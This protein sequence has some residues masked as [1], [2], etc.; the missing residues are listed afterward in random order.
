LK[1]RSNNVMRPLRVL[2]LLTQSLDYP[3]GLGRYWPIARHMARL[4]YE[5]EIAAL[6]PRWS[7]ASK[8]IF[9]QNGVTVQY[10]S[11]M[12]V[13]QSNHRREYF[14]LPQ[15]LWVSLVATTALARVAL[16]RNVNVIHIAKPHPMNGL[17]GWLGAR[18]RRTRL[19][20]DCD[21]YEAV[22][23]NFGSAWQK[24]IVKW[25]E[26]RLP[27]SVQGVTVNTCFL[28]DRCQRLG[29][30]P[31]RMRVI[32]NGFDPDRFEPVS[33]VE[34]N[35]VR[36]QWGLDGHPVVLYPGSFSLSSHPI[37]LLLDAFVEVRRRLREAR[38]LL[39]G[40]GEDIDRVAEA[41][42]QRNLS[43]AVVMTGRVDPARLPAIYAASQVVVDPVNDDDVARAR[44]PLKV[45]EALAC[46]VP[47]VTGAVGDRA[48][49]LEEGQAGVLVPPGHAPAL[50]EGLL[51]VL[52][53]PAYHAELSEGARR[54]RRRFQWNVLVQEFVRIYE[55]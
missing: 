25:W 44:S 20:L 40:G 5:V 23:N 6:H 10:V 46:G 38:L 19:Y 45:V 9:K 36:Q 27:K 39:V 24:T 12:H 8:R 52:T 49:M 16:I 4:G 35:E 11:Q 18:L 34:R 22:S 47:V 30:A 15:L 32:P 54:T 43:P 17:A 37:L 51:R 53:D 55:V 13:R 48:M 33:L 1:K 42:R 3:S 2:F 41:V 29:L 50:A 26:D 21:D 14:A 7:A 31:E 28:R